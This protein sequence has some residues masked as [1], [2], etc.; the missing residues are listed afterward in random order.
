MTDKQMRRSIGAY[1]WALLIY[2]GI[3][4]LCVIMVLVVDLVYAALTAAAQGQDVMTA[5][6]IA[7]DAA[8]SNGWGYLL[9]CGIAALVIRLWKGKSFWQDM[10]ATKQAMTGKDFWILTMLLISGQLVFQIFASAMEFLLNLVGLSALE[11]IEAASGGADTFSMFLYMGLGAPIVEE[12]VFRGAIMRGLQPFGKRFAILTSAILFGLFHGN[13]VQSPYAFVMGLILGY[14]AMEYSMVWAMALHMLNNL[15]LGDMFTR[16]TLWMGAGADLL[17][18]ALIGICSV[19]S[20]A[21]LVLR[22]K[23]ICAYGAADPIDG[24]AMKC[25]CLSLPNILFFVIMTVSAVAMLFL[26]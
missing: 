19:A 20:V 18:Y 13:I 11:A 16:L 17:F 25:F 15:V 12:L 8:V 9:A 5:I 6:E 14:T 26:V 3:L 22:R 24:R 1:T 21:V 4:N 7:T 10:F 23:Q 2:F